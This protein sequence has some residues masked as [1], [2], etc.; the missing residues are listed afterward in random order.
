DAQARIDARKAMA[1]AEA[2]AARKKAEEA[3][4][5]QQSLGSALQ[6]AEQAFLSGNL[7]QADQ[8]LSAAGKLAPGDPQVMVWRKRLDAA[9]NERNW[10]YGLAAAGGGVVLVGGMVLLMRA[11]GQKEP[12]LEVI[13]G[14][15]KG[16]RFN[17]DQ[18]VIHLGA[19]PED[20][21]VKNDIV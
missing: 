6:Q 8:A 21:G 4:Q 11:R 15:D 1:G 16:K 7:G 9:R 18:D 2:E 17:I 20:G 13:S 10:V 5:K 19:I 14:L 3:A 12:Y